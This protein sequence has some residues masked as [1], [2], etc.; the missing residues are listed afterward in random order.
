[1]SS[2]KGIGVT[3][4]NQK[5]TNT[6]STIWINRPVKQAVP[7][8]THFGEMRFRGAHH[9]P[10]TP[11]AS[12]I[13][14]LEQNQSKSKNQAQNQPQ[15]PGVGRKLAMAWL[16]LTQLASPGIFIPRPTL[17][18]EIIQTTANDADKNNAEKTEA[19]KAFESV[20][21]QYSNRELS[22]KQA[23]EKLKDVKQQNLSPR[24]QGLHQLFDHHLQREQFESENLLKYLHLGVELAPPSEEDAHRPDLEAAKDKIKPKALLL[25]QGGIGEKDYNQLLQMDHFVSLTAPQLADVAKAEFD[26]LEKEMNALAQKIDGQS[27]WRKTYETLRKLHPTKQDLLE[28]YRKEVVRARQFLQDQ[29]LN[30]IPP[31]KLR[32]IETPGWYR[33]SIPFAAYLPRGNGHGDFM[34]TSVL[35]PDPAK[36][37]EQLRAH[38]YGFIPSVVIHEAF[39]GH[40]LQHAHTDRVERDTTTDEG[41][42]TQQVYELTP[43]SPFFGEGWAV[44]GE[45]VALEKGYYKPGSGP[46]N[47]EQVKLVALRSLLWRAARAYLDPKVNTGQM[48]Y[49][50]AV[51]FLGDNVVMEQ[52]RAEMEVNR[53]FRRPTEVAS[54]MVGKMQ[55]QQLRK[56]L[57]QKEGKNF[58]LKAFHDKLLS[59]GQ[60]IPVPPLARIL[61]DESV[62]LPLPTPSDASEKK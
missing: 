44:Y 7:F 6:T 36:E 26:R 38:N 49:Q 16:T 58:Q 47:E 62:A 15:N 32:V 59:E 23:T 10:K 52:D 51:Q 8:K 37:D 20:V 1:L 21:N 53:Y 19:K 12:G 2:L 57:E 61:Y 54:Y 22:P 56:Q 4:E 27:D 39:P 28:T 29:D 60:E 43:Y 42:T 45:E 11:P 41:R 5:V 13:P 3:G 24:Y 33:E 35:D 31:E 9:S 25:K 50:E 46:M 14:T 30:S 17:A 18:S 48:T 55:F 34:V 40:H